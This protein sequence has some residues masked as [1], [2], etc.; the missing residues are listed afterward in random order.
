[1]ATTKTARRP[2]AMQRRARPR[3]RR[4]RRATEGAAMT[5]ETICSSSFSELCRNH[6]AMAKSGTPTKKAQEKI[7]QS[8]L[9]E[10][11]PRREVHEKRK[12]HA[13]RS[14]WTSVMMPLLTCMRPG[15]AFLPSACEPNC[16]S[17]LRGASRRAR[18][19]AGRARQTTCDPALLL[20]VIFHQRRWR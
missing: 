14:A 9:V 2:T 11:H 18:P 8:A 10:Q 13:S 3:W 15:G 6:R 5:F 20:S 7:S 4:S 1:L 19:R 17:C 16:A 12:T